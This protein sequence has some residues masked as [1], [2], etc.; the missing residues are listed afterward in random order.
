MVSDSLLITS[1]LVA[2]M[3]MYSL[4]TKLG[5]KKTSLFV[6]GHCQANIWCLHRLS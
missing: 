2:E 3:R 4:F 1:E 5:K 6:S